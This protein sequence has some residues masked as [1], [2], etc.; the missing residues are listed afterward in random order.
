MNSSTE[1]NSAAYSP[2]PELQVTDIVQYKK[3]IESHVIKHGSK[4]IIKN[5]TRNNITDQEP[6]EVRGRP[7]ADYLWRSLCEGHHAGSKRH[8]M[9]IQRTLQK[10]S[11]KIG[12]KA[13]LIATCYFSNSEE[14][15]ITVDG[16]HCHV[17]G[18]ADVKEAILQ[19][20]QEGYNA[21]SVRFA[22]H[23]AFHSHNEASTSIPHRDNFIHSEDV[24]NI[25][26]KVFDRAYKRHDDQK[27]SAKLWLNHLET[28]N[29]NLFIDN[30]YDSSFTFGFY[31]TW[32]ASLLA[33]TKDFS[34]G[35]T[36]NT[37]V[38]KD[39]LLY[40]LVIRH[41][42]TGTGCPLY[43]LKHSASLCPEKITIDMSGVEENA[44]RNILP[45]VNIQWCLFH[46]LRAVSQQ[47]RAKLVLESLSDSKKAHQAVI[48]QLKEM[49][50]E[51]SRAEYTRK[52]SQ[53]IQEFSIYPAFM[54]YFKNSYLDNDRF[55]KWTRA[56]QPDR[57]INMETNNYAESWHNQL[58]TSYLQSRR[59]RRVDRLVYIL[60]NDV[61][62][63]FISNIN[64][65]RMNVGR[66]E[67]EAEE[68]NIHVAM[69]MISE[70]ER[71]S[72]Y[73]VQS[74]NNADETYEVRV[75]NDTV[76]S[77]SCPDFRYRN[78]ACKHMFLLG[79][80]TKYDVWRDPAYT[81]VSSIEGLQS[82][83]EPEL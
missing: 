71:A 60:V 44:I 20:L 64:R 63:D 52:L 22:M 12:C 54:L 68:V 9:V 4:W 11:K 53:F 82:E 50:W 77:C 74:F 79:R 46:V 19:R 13:R 32:Q 72:L 56:Y 24:Y 81:E 23:R 58:K 29:Y 17:L 40:T 37:T 70:V 76:K 16:N 33:K 14:V 26:R 65:I 51:N 57:Y 1:I 2:V 8:A 25:F 27:A 42:E 83:P 75:D 48:S 6:N 69:D 31:S 5:T 41:A 3:V 47:V 35:V 38:F 34:L 28:K 73:N 15:V 66:T 45:S 80:C 39:G 7:R 30:E 61:E 67:L 43:H 21:R 49:M 36:H 18:S 62:E 10:K 78:R 59:N 55:I